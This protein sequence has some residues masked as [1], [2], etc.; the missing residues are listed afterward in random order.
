MTNA[1]G[2][3]I[4][5]VILNLGELLP[6]ET[7]E[8]Y[9]KKGYNWNNV[10]I[11]SN[12]A[13]VLG[14]LISFLLIS[15]ANLDKNLGQ[16]IVPFATTIVAYITIQSFMTDL[17]ILLINRN[18]LRVGYLS[19]Y[20]LTIYNIFT[21]EEFRANLYIVL[22]F[23]ILLILIFILSSIGASDV[24]A[25]AVSIPYA[26]SLNGYIA[27]YMF[28]ATLLLI[29]LYMYIKRWIYIKRKTNAIIKKQKFTGIKNKM[30]EMM[31]MQHIKK[32]F[33]K[34]YNKTNKGEPVGPF[35]LAPFLFFLLAYPILI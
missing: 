31:S 4:G 28:I 35:M 12:L 29:A 9:I 17:R 30:Y 22:G 34:E 21:I 8:A 13:A 18:I 1:I 5:I 27:L 15:K 2:I 20:V 7:K 6:N 32:D 14:G 11:C 25:M 19:M 23:T 3:L 24:R 10:I 16:N 26:L 33:V